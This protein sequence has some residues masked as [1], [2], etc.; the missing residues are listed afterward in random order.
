M[1]DA[2]RSASIWDIESSKSTS[3]DH[4]EG[5]ESPADMAFRYQGKIFQDWLVFLQIYPVYVQS[6][7]MNHLG[8]EKIP[9]RLLYVGDYTTQ[10]YGDYNNHYKDP[11]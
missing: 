1:S 7:R 10:L 2:G 11:Y 8:N 5:F 9:G 3:R 6:T 4:L